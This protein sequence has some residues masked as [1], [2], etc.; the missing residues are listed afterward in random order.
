M[1]DRSAI[2]KNGLYSY[3]DQMAISL[4]SSLVDPQA[5]VLYFTNANSDVKSLA[6]VLAKL[7]GKFGR[8]RGHYIHI[9]RRPRLGDVGIHGLCT[10]ED[11]IVPTLQKLKDGR[12]NSR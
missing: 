12:L 10:E 6:E 4:F 3:V 9:L 2:R 7:L 11:H 8:S 1:F 5:F